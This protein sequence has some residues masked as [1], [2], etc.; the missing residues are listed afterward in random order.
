[1]ASHKNGLVVDWG[2]IADP[3]L[4]TPLWRPRASLSLQV[5]AEATADPHNHDWAGPGFTKPGP[6]SNAGYQAGYALGKAEA[7]AGT[8]TTFPGLTTTFTHGYI[9]GHHHMTELLAR[10]ANGR[11]AEE[12]G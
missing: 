12:R 11:E 9:N 8:T 7:V 2:A 1:M 3:I 4:A 5:T 6:E 10:A